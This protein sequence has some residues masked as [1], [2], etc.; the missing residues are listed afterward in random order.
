MRKMI[1]ANVYV[2]NMGSMLDL[3]ISRYTTF[4]ELGWLTSHFQELT[5]DDIVFEN[6]IISKA[7][8]G[9]LWVIID[10]ASLNVDV[11]IFSFDMLCRHIIVRGSREGNLFLIGSYDF[12]VNG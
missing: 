8:K 11:V 1:R 12:G 9:K 7:P 5:F 3:S 4:D 6:V 2:M 10:K